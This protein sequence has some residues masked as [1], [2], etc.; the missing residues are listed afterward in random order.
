LLD[1][2]KRATA[3]GA[4]RKR[5][6]VKLFGHAKKDVAE[7]NIVLRHDTLGKKVLTHTDSASVKNRLGGE[8]RWPDE[9][10][11]K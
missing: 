3:P 4:Q 2:W 5:V 10:Q 6:S 7:E 8:K 1:A 9:F 11:C